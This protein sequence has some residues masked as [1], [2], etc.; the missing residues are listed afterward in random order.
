M[1]IA[2]KAMKNSEYTLDTWKVNALKEYLSKQGLK[3]EG[4]KAM[5]V[6]RAFAA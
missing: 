4:N 6:A 5:L 1:Q 3:V 2:K